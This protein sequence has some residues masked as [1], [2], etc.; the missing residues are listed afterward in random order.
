MRRA[1]TEWTVHVSDA[2]K[3]DLRNI[4]DWT[5]D[6]F[7]DRQARVYAGAFSELLQDLTDGPD[8]PGARRRD[9]IQAGLHTIHIARRRR[10]GRHVLLFR[11]LDDKQRTIEVLRILHDAMDVSRHLPSPLEDDDEP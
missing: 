1:G 11:V 2:A 5:A 3:A 6:H 10:K 9:D 4:V 8:I 7:G